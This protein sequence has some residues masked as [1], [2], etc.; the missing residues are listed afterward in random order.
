M[1]KRRKHIT[2]VSVNTIKKR[3]NKLAAISAIWIIVIVAMS[4][5]MG[6]AGT[7]VQVLPVLTMGGFLSVMIEIFSS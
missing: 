3:S 4:A 2:T 1:A 6:D 7:F 5:I